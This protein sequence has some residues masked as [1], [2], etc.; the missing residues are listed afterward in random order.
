MLLSMNVYKQALE[1][2]KTYM[3]NEPD[4]EPR[5]ALKQA[6]S[7]NGIPYGPEMRKFVLWAERQLR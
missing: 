3:E 1:D 6:G 4:L 5:S 7:D 2:A